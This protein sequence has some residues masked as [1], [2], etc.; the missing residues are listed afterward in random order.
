MDSVI[1]GA[2]RGDQSEC[3]GEGRLYL[4]GGEAT[5]DRGL[6][7]CLLGPPHILLGNEPLQFSRRK[8]AAL[9]IIWPSPGVPTRASCSPPCSGA[10][11]PRIGRPMASASRSAS[12][13][14]RWRTNF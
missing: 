7:L 11:C 2:T 9:L 5:S 1:E 14:S 6:R 8:T 4:G 12:C 3:D 10:I 13:A